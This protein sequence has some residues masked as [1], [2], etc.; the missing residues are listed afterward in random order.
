[1]SN[2]RIYE[3]MLSG[4]GVEDPTNPSNV[5]KFVCRGTDDDIAM[6]VAVVQSPV[7]PSFWAGLPLQKYSFEHAG[8]ELWYIDVTYGKSQQRDTGSGFRGFETSGGTQRV[9][10]SLRTVS[11]YAPPGMTAP[12]CKG[13]IGVTKDAVEGV[14]LT[15]PVFNWNE[16]H[17]VDAA[18]ITDAYIKTLFRLT[19]RKNAA[20]FKI[21]AAGECL[22]LGASGSQRNEQDWEVNFKFAASPNLV[23]LTI[24]E[25]EGI[26]KRGWDYLWVLHRD[27]TS[28]NFLVK[29]PIAAYVEEVYYDG[30]FSLLG[31]G[32]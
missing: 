23:D 11:N 4:D 28:N 24:G 27:T 13:A 18:A 16:T 19:A 25:M 7:V 3:R 2:I 32:N 6:R 15:V 22:F 9:F 14:D 1:M 31:I 30:D 26:I 20:P 17:Y 12:D 21:C 8:F 29:K 10:Q 5:K